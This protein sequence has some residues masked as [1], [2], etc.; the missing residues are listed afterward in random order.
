[1][2]NKSE[3]TVKVKKSKKPKGGPDMPEETLET[4]IVAELTQSFGGELT[5]A[6]GEQAVAAAL[7]AY[8]VKLAEFVELIG[9]G[10]GIIQSG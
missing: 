6:Q 9:S 2:T 4:P 5:E 1:M 8:R 3:P 10:D 7:A